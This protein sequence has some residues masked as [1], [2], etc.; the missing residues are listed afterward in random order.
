MIRMNMKRKIVITQHRIAF[1]LEIVFR[2]G[3]VFQCHLRFS[4]SEDFPNSEEAWNSLAWRGV[5]KLKAL[6]RNIFNTTGNLTN[7]L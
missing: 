5:N 2:N 7:S 1:D 3:I 6:K 4:L